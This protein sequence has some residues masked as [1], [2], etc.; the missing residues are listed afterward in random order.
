MSPTAKF[1]TTLG[2]NAVEQNILA[3][4]QFEFVSRPTQIQIYSIND[5]LDRVDMEVFF[6][7]ELEVSPSPIDIAA[8][9]ATGPII[10]DNLILDDV[11]MPSDRITVRLTETAGM[12][13]TVNRT[14]VKFTPLA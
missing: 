11:A 7:Q 9:I 12:A 1:E 10:P 3:G 4:S 6:G 13:A 8:V 14:L 5:P 2:A